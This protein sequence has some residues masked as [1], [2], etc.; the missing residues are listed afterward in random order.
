MSC[1]RKCA[2]KENDG[3]LT[4]YAGLCSEEK[5]VVDVHEYARTTKAC[6]NKLQVRTQGIAV[7]PSACSC[8][9]QRL[10]EL[11]LATLSSPRP[12]AAAN[13]TLIP[14]TCSGQRQRASGAG[15]AL[16]APRGPTG[17]LRESRA[18]RG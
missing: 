13:A 18:A 4:P 10:R 12:A 14:Q 8:A 7:A 11:T 17:G 2:M 9:S 1:E 5:D 16:G 6:H 15:L 3:S